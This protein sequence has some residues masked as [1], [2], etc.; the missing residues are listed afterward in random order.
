M[1]VPRWALS[2]ERDARF[3]DLARAQSEEQRALLEQQGR[4]RAEGTKN[5]WA[6]AS[7]VLPGIVQG[8]QA[9]QSHRAKM[10]E[11]ERAAARHKLN[12]DEFAA[13]APQRELGQKTAQYGLANFD[14][15]MATEE[16]WAA[17]QRRMAGEKHQLAMQPAAG[18][19]DEWSKS[20]VTADGKIIYSNKRGQERIGD[21]ATAMPNA[22]KAAPGETMLDR[23]FAKELNE[24]ETRG[25]TTAQK[26]LQKLHDARAELAASVPQDGKAAAKDPGIL[27]RIWSP[28]ESQAAS[29]RIV[30]RLPDIL[31]PESAITTREKVRG[32]ASGAMKATLGPAF[33]EREGERVMQDAYNETLDPAQN[34]VKVDAAIREIESSAENMD[35]RARY[36]A[37]HGSLRGFQPSTIAV[38]PPASPTAKQPPGTAYAGQQKSLE[39]MTDEEQEAYEASLMGAQ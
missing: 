36:F 31:R 29:G 38:K 20:G 16:Q 8:Y 24:W 33:T 2:T 22:A 37:E 25:K 5:M 1:A 6:A 39:E 28:V 34:L 12:E 15:N 19:P 35:R 11:D 21:I 23:E 27:D 3:N 4:T 10:A 17:D 30:G 26:N 14:K 7:D 18:A 13:G 9:G 32:A